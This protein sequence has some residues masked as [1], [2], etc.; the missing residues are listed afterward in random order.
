MAKKKRCPKHEEHVDETW[1]I[2]YADLLTL[3]LALFI[4]LFATSQTD[5]QKL[6]EMSKVFSI[7]FTSQKGVMG[8]AS[9]QPS[10]QKHSTDNNEK[11]SDQ[12]EASRQLIPPTQGEMANMQKKL[13]QYI[14]MQ[15]LPGY[16]VTSMTDEGLM[17]T[18]KDIA[19]FPSGSSELL[20]EAQ[21]IAYDLSIMFEKSQE[22]V[23]IAG[24]T[25]DKPSEGST[26]SSNWELSSAR[27]ISFMKEILKNPSLNPERFSAV[28]Y[29]QYQPIVPNI[30][31]ADRERNRRVEILI[32]KPA[33]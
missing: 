25:D 28:S 27:A 14:T 33:Q 26:Y 4:V 23:Q 19:L 2:P 15:N 9:I 5:K 32:R 8:D 16:M 31:D 7:I 18:I 11:T 10:N 3:L 29:G 13:N 1:L 20:P 17:I 12:G 30:T 21:K 24:H 6:M 22:K